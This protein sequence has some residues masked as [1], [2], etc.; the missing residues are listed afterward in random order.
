[1]REKD[2]CGY[3]KIEP[4]KENTANTCKHCD[5][6]GI[7]VKSI[8]INS[9]LREEKLN[10]VENDDNFYFCKNPDCEIVYFNNKKNLYFN[11]KDVKVRVGL[12][13]KNPPIPVCYCFNI[14]K[15]QII[16]ELTEKGNSK[17]IQYVKNM[18]KMGKCSC[19]VKNPTGRCCLDT[20][21]NIN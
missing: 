9:I 7:K 19:E 3:C 10:L 5:T 11:K 12:K 16:S 8:T 18:I 17:S 20:I 15:E 14:T 1:M 13:E 6:R 4:I 2:S 21:L